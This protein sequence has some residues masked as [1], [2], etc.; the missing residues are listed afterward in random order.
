IPGEDFSF[1]NPARTVNFRR[2]GFNG[3]LA[4]DYRTLEG[5]SST[6]KLRS[7]EFLAFRGVFPTVKQFVVSWGI[8]QAR[9][10]EWVV[11]DQ[12]ELPYLDGELKRSFASDGGLYVSRIGV[13]RSVAPHL[14]VGMGLD[15]MIGRTRQSRTLDFGTSS[16]LAGSELYSYRYSCFRPTIGLLAGYRHFSLGLSLSVPKTCDIKKQVTFSSGYLATET[17]ELDY[18]AL[19]RIGAAVNLTPRSLVVAD[20]E[21]EGWGGLKQTLE[22]RLSPADQ[23]RFCLGYELLPST[24]EQRRFYRK[25]PLRVGYSRTSYPFRIDGEP[26]YEQFFTFGTGVYFG[27]GGGLV[28]IACEIGKRRAVAGGYPEEGLFRLV[29]SLSAFE[30]WVS[31]PRRK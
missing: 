5:P 2:S 12:V 11:D 10:M 16:Y 25:V 23:W 4:Q 24:A 17:V 26:V 13:A 28:D 8:F 15:W 3:V 29:V 18:P 20:L 6:D 14:A 21:Y 31:R 1:T 27:Q 7:T 19:W 22:P 30:K 9:D